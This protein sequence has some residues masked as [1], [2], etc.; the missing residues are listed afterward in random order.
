MKRRVTIAFASAI[1]TC[2][3]SSSMSAQILTRSGELNAINATECTSPK[4]HQNISRNIV[5]ET[6]IRMQNTRSTNEG[7]DSYSS[8]ITEVDGLAKHYAKESAGITLSWGMFPTYYE[9]TDHP[10]EI[11]FGDNGEVYFHNIMNGYDWADSYIKGQLDGDKITVELPQMIQDLGMGEAVLLTGI[12][13]FENSEDDTVGFELDS[14]LKSITYSVSEDGV[15]SL[16]VPSEETGIGYTYLS[17]GMWV[18]YVDYYQVYRPSDRTPVTLP[19]SAVVEQWSYVAGDYGYF[20]KVAYDGDDIYIGG[21][22]PMMPDSWIKG[23]LEGDKATFANNQYIGVANDSYFVTV[24]FGQ[25]TPNASGVPVISLLDKDAVYVM[26]YDKENKTLR[27]DNKEMLMIFNTST[28]EIRY[29]TII[30]DPQLNYQPSKSGTPRGATDLGYT[31]LWV[32]YYGYSIFGFRLSMVSQE[33]TLLDTDYLYY[34]LFV[35]GEQIE[36]DPE[37]YTNISEHMTDIPFYFTNDNEF[38]ARNVLTREIGIYDSDIKSLGVQIVYY[39]DNVETEGP[40]VTLDLEPTIVSPITDVNVVNVEY[41]D[42]T[43]KK[44]SVNTKGVIMKRTTYSDG[45]ITSSKIINN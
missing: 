38:F 28:D 13:Y 11:V 27:A 22:S 15:I 6:V 14:E 42:L 9:T 31:N 40:V 12:H 21:L 35:N 24:Q 7:S 25:E 45:Q 4:R 33:G 20:L 41:F 17:D 36:I 30:Q 18:G 39:L 43:G 32:D 37:T 10:S 3:L 26:T 23:T 5:S 19:D 2:S 1:I 34:R 44:T 29:I 8:P 16:D